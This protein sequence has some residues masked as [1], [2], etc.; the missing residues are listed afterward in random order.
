MTVIEDTKKG[1]IVVK[2]SVICGVVTHALRFTVAQD[3][4][5]TMIMRSITEESGGKLEKGDRIIGLD[6]DDIRTWTL[7]RGKHISDPSD[8]MTSKRS[9]ALVV[10]Q[11]LTDLRAPM[12]VVVTFSFSRKVRIDGK[13]ESEE[14]GEERRSEEPQQ[15]AP[16]EELTRPERDGAGG[17]DDDDDI[18][19]CRH[20]S[21]YSEYPH[22]GGDEGDIDDEEEGDSVPELPQSR[23]QRSSVFSDYASADI[24]EDDFAP[25]PPPAHSQESKQPQR[26][27]VFS[28]YASVDIDEDDFVPPQPTGSATQKPF[29]SSAPFA[30]TP[31]ALAPST[32]PKVSKVWQVDPMVEI[33]SLRAENEDLQMEVDRLNSLI[34]AMTKERDDSRQEAHEYRMK[35]EAAES[36]RIEFLHQVSS[37]GRSTNDLMKCS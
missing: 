28:D 6:N 27:S 13:D 15:P 32:Q 23:Q 7:A 34:L 17:G 19:N 9:S 20:S 5:P 24:D 35:Y 29:S 4:F 31:S 26:P 14:F 36:E 33:V 2:V 12:G 37:A 25:P 18:P 16:N 8:P 1:V 30:P 10:V 3:V 21:V 11:R 22:G